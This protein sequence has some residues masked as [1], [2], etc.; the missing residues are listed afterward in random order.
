M[1]VVGTAG[2]GAWPPPGL[3]PARTPLAVRACGHGRGRWWRDLCR[4]NKEVPDKRALEKLQAQKTRNWK[5]E[6]KYD[7]VGDCRARAQLGGG[8][9]RLM[10]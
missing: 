7:A 9:W 5:E 4:S 1:A 6:F 2:G 10:R 8:E 3:C